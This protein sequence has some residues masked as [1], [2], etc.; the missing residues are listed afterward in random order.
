[1]ASPLFGGESRQVERVIY[2]PGVAPRP[3]DE[4]SSYWHSTRE[5]VDWVRVERVECSC[6]RVFDDVREMSRR[7]RRRRTC[8]NCQHDRRGPHEYVAASG[9]PLHAVRLTLPKRVTLPADA[10]G[11]LRTEDPELA[12]ILNRMTEL[13][14]VAP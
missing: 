13:K 3:D 7:G 5:I 12:E 4:P 8:R 9:A 1:M 14:R 11:V 2:G 6:G 10:D